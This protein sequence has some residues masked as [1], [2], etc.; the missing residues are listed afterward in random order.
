VKAGDGAVIPGGIPH[1]AVTH[2][3]ACRVLD[4]FSPARKDFEE[5]LARA[6]QCR[7]Q[8]RNAQPADSIRPE[9]QSI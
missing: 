6:L 2:D 9:A 5:K 8:G 3:K 7:K 4:I 1:S